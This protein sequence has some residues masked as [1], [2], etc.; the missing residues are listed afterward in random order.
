MP[1]R[2]WI[3]LFFGVGATPSLPYHSLPCWVDGLI[4]PG[5]AATDS[6]ILLLYESSTGLQ[7]LGISWY[8]FLGGQVPLLSNAQWR[9]PSRI[10]CDYGF[11][12]RLC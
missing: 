2:P 7:G 10:T 9:P 8:S 6:L 5:M 4:N 12:I 11:E 1:W 3:A